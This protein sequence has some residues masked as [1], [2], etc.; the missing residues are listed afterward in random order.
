V[1]IEALAEGT[2]ESPPQTST[3]KSRAAQD[4]LGLLR[5]SFNA[6]T[7]QLPRFAW[8]ID[9][10]TRNLQTSRAGTRAPP[11]THGNVLES[12]PTAAFRWT[13]DRASCAPIR[14]PRV[15]SART[16]RSRN[17]RRASRPESSRVCTK[18]H[19]PLLRM[20]VVSADEVEMVVAG[21]VLHAAVTVSSLGRAA[22]T[23]G[24]VLVVDDL[25]ELLSR[26]NPAWLAES[27]SP[28]RARNQNPLTPINFLPSAHPPLSAHGIRTAEPLDSRT[29]PPRRESSS[30][31]RTRS[32]HGLAALVTILSIRRFHRPNSKPPASTKSSA[33]RS[34]FLRRL[35]RI[36]L[37]SFLSDPFPHPRRRRASPRR[38]R[39]LIDNAAEALNRRRANIHVDTSFNSESDSSKLPSKI[40]AQGISP[41]RQGQTIL[42]HFSTK[43]RVPDSVSPSLPASSPNTTAFSRRR[44]LPP[45]VLRFIPNFLPRNRRCAR[46]YKLFRKASPRIPCQVTRLQRS[47]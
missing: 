15:S 39:Q 31:Y 45:S 46:S 12:I 44:Q 22:P 8:Q 3:I 35:D 14:R 34:R 25:T 47:K 36:I 4:E 6:M 30:P 17:A 37:S 19:A 11:P 2:R 38:N 7:T 29:D 41:A 24:Y 21:R 23:P 40:P 32:R 27:R 20:G 1:P 16:P 43:R 28:H 10:F 18:P 26:K 5:K 13:R 9:Q 42:P 33:K